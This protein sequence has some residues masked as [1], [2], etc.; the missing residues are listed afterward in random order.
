MSL[1]RHR[2]AVGSA[3]SRTAGVTQDPTQD[4]ATVPVAWGPR[5]AGVVGD[6]TRC[7]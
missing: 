3:V 6:K 4:S 2:L 1:N 5:V 7:R